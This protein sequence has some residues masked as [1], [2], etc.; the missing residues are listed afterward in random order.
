MERSAHLLARA[1]MHEQ[2]ASTSRPG[3]F[4]ERHHRA[5]ARRRHL[6]ATLADIA[7]RERARLADIG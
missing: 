2:V 7:M 4:T 3:S 1:R 5:L 6:Q